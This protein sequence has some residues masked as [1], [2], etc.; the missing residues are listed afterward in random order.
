MVQ[1]SKVILWNIQKIPVDFF[2]KDE[3]IS[4]TLRIFLQKSTLDSYF[5]YSLKQ[6]K[7]L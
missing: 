6:G 2:I 3:I 7:H 5:P 1:N 4:F